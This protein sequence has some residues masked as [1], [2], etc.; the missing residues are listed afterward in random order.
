VAARSSR[1]AVP[2][3][4]ISDVGKVIVFNIRFHAPE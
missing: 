1:V 4:A 2:D 3:S